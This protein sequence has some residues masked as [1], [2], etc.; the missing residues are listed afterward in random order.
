MGQLVGGLGLGA[1]WGTLEANRGGPGTVW[2]G[3]GMRRGMGEL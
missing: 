3:W 1:G 2:G